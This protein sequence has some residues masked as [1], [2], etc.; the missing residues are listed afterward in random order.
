MFHGFFKSS[1]KF[2]S[3]FYKIQPISKQLTAL[4]RRFKEK[5]MKKLKIKSEF[6]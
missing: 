4:R 2:L 3:K 1:K 6:F 5:K